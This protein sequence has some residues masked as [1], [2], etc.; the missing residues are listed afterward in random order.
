MMCYPSKLNTKKDNLYKIY[1]CTR[2]IK[3]SNYVRYIVYFYYM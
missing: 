3:E 2:K 1:I